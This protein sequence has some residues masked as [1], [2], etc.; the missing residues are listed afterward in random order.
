MSLL[1]HTL[2][3]L[4]VYQTLGVRVYRRATCAAVHDPVSERPSP[5]TSSD[6]NPTRAVGQTNIFYCSC[7]QDDSQNLT[8]QP[9]DLRQCK[10]L[11]A[12]FCGRLGCQVIGPFNVR[13]QFDAKAE[14]EGSSNFMLLRKAIQK[15]L[16]DKVG[17][18]NA[19]KTFV[20]A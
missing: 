5:H 7:F 8:S 10:L 19:N 15:L 14:F 11:A 6:T 18:E 1:N 17:P 16:M 13:Q 12:H 2:L 9:V 3:Y 20:G 4:S